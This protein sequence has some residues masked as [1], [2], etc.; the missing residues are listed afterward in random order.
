MIST[1]HY[2]LLWFL[3]EQLNDFVKVNEGRNGRIIWRRRFVEPLEPR[4]ALAAC[5]DTIN[6]RSKLVHND[7]P[8]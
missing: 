3:S 8:L 7:T 4:T 2:S 6:V 1:Q 5:K